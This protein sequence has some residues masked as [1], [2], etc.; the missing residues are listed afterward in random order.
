MTSPRAATARG[1]DLPPRLPDRNRFPLRIGPFLFRLDG[2]W[3]ELGKDLGPWRADEPPASDRPHQVIDLAL[4]PRTAPAFAARDPSAT[5]TFGTPAWRFERPP[6]W[7]AEGEGIATVRAELNATGPRVRRF[8]MRSLLRFLVSESLLR[9]GGVALHAAAITRPGGV[10]VLMADS[11]G[12]KTT[13]ATRFG[14]DGVL[15]DDF[16]LVVPGPAGFTVHPSPFPGREQTPASGR[17][18]P[19]W[20]MAEIVKADRARFARWTRPETVAAILRHAIVTTADL[21]A[22]GRL[23]D[24]AMRLSDAVPCGALSLS[25]RTTPWASL[26]EPR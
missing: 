2:A 23:L 24:V 18:A 12:G 21:D 11:G 4:F 15:A 8:A 5:G 1:P 17:G 22:R 19:L 16:C 25:L 14:G 9:I 26:G 3:P 7:M 13:A 6:W 10:A 20:R